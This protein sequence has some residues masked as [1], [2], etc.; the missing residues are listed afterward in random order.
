[1]QVERKY[2]S[3]K[4]LKQESGKA[5][6][7]LNIPFVVNSSAH[8]FVESLILAFENLLEQVVRVSPHLSSFFHHPNKPVG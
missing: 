6:N 8:Q 5:L 2:K 3:T 1:M 4:A 7:L